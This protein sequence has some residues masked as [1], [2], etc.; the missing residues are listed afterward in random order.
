MTEQE[1]EPFQE[2]QAVVEMSVICLIEGIADVLGI[3]KDA[4]PVKKLFSSIPKVIHHDVNLKD[5]LAFYEMSKAVSVE[6]LR[7]IKASPEQ[8]E[9]EIAILQKELK[10]C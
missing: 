4:F 10:S 5:F 8:A 7:K 6:A 9:N 2:L 3:D 1:N